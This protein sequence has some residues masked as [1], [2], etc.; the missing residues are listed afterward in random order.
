MDVEQLYTGNSGT[1]D[2]TAR[3][4]AATIIA[5]IEVSTGVKSDTTS[6]SPYDVRSKPK[7]EANNNPVGPKKKNS[8]D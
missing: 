8:C 6:G 2:S 7:P 1:S 5:L 3:F 4:Q